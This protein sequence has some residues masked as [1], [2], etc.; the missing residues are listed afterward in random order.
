MMILHGFMF[1][2]NAL[3]FTLVI[4]RTNIAR[5]LER[6]NPWSPGLDPHALR[7]L[8]QHPSWTGRR[9]TESFT[10]EEVDR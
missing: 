7:S 9:P 8:H 6:P 3:L 10:D 4:Y 1:L 2:I 5:R